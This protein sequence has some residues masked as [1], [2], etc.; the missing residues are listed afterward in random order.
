MAIFDFAFLS[1][2]FGDGAA[3]QNGKDRRPGRKKRDGDGRW[4]FVFVRSEGP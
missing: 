1:V 2:G 3:V 4:M